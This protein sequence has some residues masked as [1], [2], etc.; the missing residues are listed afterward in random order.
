MNTTSE[1]NDNGNDTRTGLPFGETEDESPFLDQVCNRMME[2]WNAFIK[3]HGH[4]PKFASVTLRYDGEDEEGEDRIK[5][6]G[7]DRTNTE[8]DPDDNGVVFYA[9]GIEEL[10]QI[11]TDR[12][13]DFVITDIYEFYD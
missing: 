11:N 7:F 1:Y 5:V 10:C 3:E 6:S 13:A 9:D 4:E 8:N 12:I 2:M